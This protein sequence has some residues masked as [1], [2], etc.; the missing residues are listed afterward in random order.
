MSKFTYPE[1]VKH[2][3]DVAISQSGSGARVAASI[4]VSANSGSFKVEIPDLCLLDHKNLAAAY[5]V[6]SG[7]VST[8]RD[9]GS[10]VENGYKLIDDIF[11]EWKGVLLKEEYAND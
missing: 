10:Q 11:H 1:A 6:I 4:L 9:A 7:R 3:V 8:H 2:L 5:A